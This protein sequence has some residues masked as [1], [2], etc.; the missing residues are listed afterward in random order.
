[1]TMPSNPAAQL[2]DLIGDTPLLELRHVVG[3][4]PEDVK[5]FAKAE[6]LNPGG[7]VKDRAVANIIREAERE[8]RLT[9]EKALLDATSGNAG[10]SYAM[11]CASKG[12]EA[13]LAVPENVSPERRQILDAYGATLVMTD[14]LEGSDGA[15]LKA[16]E[17][18]D[19]DPERYFYADQYQNDANWMAHYETTGPEISRQTDDQVTHFVSGIGTGGTLMG[20]GRFL[21]ERIPQAEI[22]GVEPNSPLHG[23]EGL[24]HMDS[25]ITPPIYD[26]EFPDRIVE[27]ETERAQ[28]LTRRLAGEEGLLVGPSSGAALTAALEV[29]K[30]I[31]HGRV[32]VIFPDRGERYLNEIFWRRK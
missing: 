18:A 19:E 23:L 13:H 14:P 17:I 8:K 20:T 2:T 30:D 11:I 1:M 6:W 9:Q 32:V 4:T 31:G 12:Y 15:I 21:R 26:P 27:V 28:D 3:D 10:I 29:A 25:S 7:S 5:V 24:K 16:R 22:I